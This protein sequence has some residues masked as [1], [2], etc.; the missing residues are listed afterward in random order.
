MPRTMVSAR[1]PEELD[2]KLET[3]AGLTRRSKAYLLHQALEQYVHEKVRLYHAID[4]AVKEADADG[5][6]VSDKD[7]RAWLNSWGKPD[8][9]PPPRVRPRDEPD[10]D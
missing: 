10:D 8:E 4:E 7:M 3:L 1:I 6:Y 5:S 2:G 9:L